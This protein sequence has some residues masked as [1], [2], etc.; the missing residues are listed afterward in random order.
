[1]GL[2]SVR[3]VLA[4]L[5]VLA[6][7]AMSSDARAQGLPSGPLKIVTSV[8]AGAAPDVITRLVAEHLTRLWGHQVIVIN[9]PGGAGAVAIKAVSSAPSDGSTLYMALATNFIALPEL[10]KNF[11]VD[12][13][14]DFAPVGFIG[15]QPIMIGAAPSLGIGTLPELIALLKQRPGELNIG[16]G[17]RGS[18]LHFTGEW[19]RSASGT[20][21]TLLH[22]AGGAQ[23]LPDLM[24][25]RLQATI[26]AIAS[27][28]GAIDGGQVRPLAVTVL[29][30]L[31]NF[32]Q[33]PT[34]AE[35]L[36]GF[37]SMGW[38]AL[39]AP[40]G[41]PAPV[42]KKISD[43]LRTVL[44]KPEL[45]QRL[46]DLGTYVRPTTPEELTA[47]IREQQAIWRPV[48]AETAKQIN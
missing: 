23:A 42:V 32:P 35:T 41:T 10:Q 47:F 40:A 16:G 34:V 43:D 3:S 8:G 20:K 1:M 14:H 29:K 7:S 15:E 37:Q 38:M 19:L 22:Y 46:A 4:L 36:P 24:G 21:F 5:S 31:D 44:A 28:R 11:P 12:V 30:R 2:R 39:M 18:I 13:L 9:Q 6:L 27:M 26:D 45:K 33:V 17:N 48:I 25:G